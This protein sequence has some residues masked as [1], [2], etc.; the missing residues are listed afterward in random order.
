MFKLVVIDD[1][2]KARDVIYS[3][4]KKY[5]KSIDVVGVA[6]GVK[7]GIELIKTHKPDIVLLDI[8]MHDGTGFDLLNKFKSID[9]KV[10]FITAHEEY[11]LKAFKFSAMD[12]ILKPID[13]DELIAAIERTEN[14]LKQGSLQ[15]IEVFEGNYLNNNKELKKII[16]RTLDCIYAVK[17]K[18]IVRCEAEESYTTFFLNDGQKIVISK[19]LKEYDELLSSYGFFRTHQSHLINLDYFEKYKKTGG[20]Y[21]VLKDKSSVP[22]SSRKKEMFLQTINQL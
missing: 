18:D 21:A 15:N 17:I 12:Y 10:I 8:E 5:C 20:G 2:K 14:D 9:F 1:V 13:A 4:V 19:P 3:I 6:D 11:A 16:L 7:S 22:V